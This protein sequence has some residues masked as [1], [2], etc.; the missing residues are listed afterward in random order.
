MSKFD[1]ILRFQHNLNLN[2]FS[3]TIDASL[4]L[5][6]K[7]TVSITAQRLQ[8][9][10]HQQFTSFHSQTNKPVHELSLI[11][12]NEQYLL[13]S[14]NNTQ[15]SFSSS[16]TCIHH[17]FVY[18][19]MK[20]PQ[21]LA[22]ELDEQSL[23]YCELLHYVQVLSVTLLNEYNVVPGEVVCQCVERS[24]SMVIGI[25]GIEMA[26][27]VYCPLSPRDP[28]HRL[29]ALT[30]QIQSRL[31]LVHD[32]TKTKFDGDT[33]S[34]NIDSI[35]IINNLNSDMNSNCLSSVIMNGGEIAY[36]IFT[37]GSSGIPKAVQLRQ[38]NLINSISGFVQTDALHEDDVTIQIASSTFDA[39]ILEIV[40]SLICGATIVMLHPQGESMS[41]AFIRVLMQFVAQSCRVWNLYGPA[42]ATLGTS[43]HLIDVISDMHDLPIGKPL[44]RYI[45]LLLNSFLQPVMIQEEGELFVGGLGVFAGYLGRDDLTTKALIEIDGQLFYQT[46]DLVTID[47]NGLLHY[48]GRK[49]HQIKLHGQRIELGEIERCLLSTISISACVVM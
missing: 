35:L 19:V 17:E 37:S 44:P 9:M 10:L 11:L 30:Q 25:M 36:T 8:T 43:C 28:Q 15:I 14:L 16:R 23:T 41:L 4:D 5:F 3:C 20:H 1:F 49:D 45:C 2:E 38:Q 13:Q 47:N 31:V 7:E 42:E 39:H 22:V 48:Q 33:I 27:G 12:S 18:R 24:L 21:K 40:G 34:L 46:G 6:N 29:H 26:G 32:L